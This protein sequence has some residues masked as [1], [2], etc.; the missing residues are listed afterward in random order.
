MGNEN[1]HT[2]W[3]PTGNSKAMSIHTESDG[4]QI[5]PQLSA[6]SRNWLCT[7]TCRFV[8]FQNTCFLEISR[9]QNNW[10]MPNQP[11]SEDTKS[12]FCMIF[13]GK[14][15]TPEDS[16]TFPSQTLFSSNADNSENAQ[17]HQLVKA[18]FGHL[19]EKHVLGARKILLGMEKNA[20]GK[21]WTQNGRKYSRIQRNVKIK[22][23]K[24]VDRQTDRKM[25]IFES[26]ATKQSL[27][28]LAALLWTAGNRKVYAETPAVCDH[29][30]VETASPP[31]AALVQEQTR[32][33]QSRM[34]GG[35]RGQDPWSQ[36]FS[37]QNPAPFSKLDTSGYLRDWTNKSW[38]THTKNQ[39]WF[40]QDSANYDFVLFF[41]VAQICL[42]NKFSKAEWQFATK[43]L[44]VV[45]PPKEK[46]GS[47]GKLRAKTCKFLDLDIPRS[48]LTK[49]LNPG[50]PPVAPSS[51]VKTVFKLSRKSLFP[52][53]SDPR[54]QSLITRSLTRY[55]RTQRNPHNPNCFYSGHF[56]QGFRT[57]HLFCLVLW[58]KIFCG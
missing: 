9:K 10:K 57:W 28:Y 26:N 54:E 39:Y 29:S 16:H 49:I 51:C 6:P 47:V 58:N 55:C 48:I 14:W 3:R 2:V 7:P 56:L 33:A 20:S 5:F 37:V 19:C 23:N 8:L 36:D 52:A 50:S 12:F 34:F 46:F 18:I 1:P 40:V 11:I 15:P 25:N 31:A 44:S 24:Q 30:S 42:W 17:P 32:E 21:V 41:S 22:E 43:T 38:G 27:E 35:P 13:V 53:S 4:P 45:K